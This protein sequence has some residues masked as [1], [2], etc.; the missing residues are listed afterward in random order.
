MQKPKV[1]PSPKIFE[2][3]QNRIED[4]LQAVYQRDCTER[5]KIAE[6]IQEMND[7]NM[8]WKL[9]AAYTTEIEAVPSDYD[10]S[11]DA[12]KAL[13]ARIYIAGTLRGAAAI[14]V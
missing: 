2:W 9:M 1:D 4:G 8:F 11:N 3:Y 14:E 12:L 7:S 10:R 5:Q 6:I 13:L